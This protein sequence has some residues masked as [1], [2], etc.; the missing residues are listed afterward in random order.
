[1]RN[2]RVLPGGAQRP[3]LSE[4]NLQRQ[5]VQLAE[6]FGWEHVH[7]RPAMTK[8]G[9]RT[10]GS[11][12]MAK[13]WPDLVLVRVRDRR[14][15]FAELKADGAKLT[16]DQIQVRQVLQYLESIRLRGFGGCHDN[17]EHCDCPRV[18]V[19]LWRPADW[20]TIEAT[21]R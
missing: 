19:H 7:F 21:L 12:T 5:V 6:I 11:G 9:W 15:I 13:G 18:E 16:P 1:M 20:D 4:L 17:D 3:K 8:H 2:V 14:L 10:A